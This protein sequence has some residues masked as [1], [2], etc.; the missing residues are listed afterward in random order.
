MD[1]SSFSISG[2]L[3]F[4][5]EIPF[6]SLPPKSA[7]LRAGSPRIARG[8]ISS[9]DPIPC[10]LNI[11]DFEARFFFLF[12][13]TLLSLNI[14]IFFFFVL[15]SYVQAVDTRFPCARDSGRPGFRSISFERWIA[16]ISRARML[17]HPLS[18]SGGISP[19]FRRKKDE[20]FSVLFDYRKFRDNRRRLVKDFSF[21]Q[22]EKLERM[23]HEFSFILVVET[24]KVISH[25]CPLF[26]R[27]VIVK[28]RG[29]KVVSNASNN[30]AK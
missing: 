5:I 18:L 23:L 26:D 10:N 9:I 15:H 3:S 2:C 8:N 28:V 13:A 30:K 12:S 27:R 16:T 6:D 24:T 4:E 22:L 11:L 1:L 20:N 29:G 25:L 7:I 17:S 14:S 21:F 19:P